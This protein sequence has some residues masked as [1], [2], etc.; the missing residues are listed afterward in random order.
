MK[1]I[2]FVYLLTLSLFGLFSSNAISSTSPPPAISDL[3]SESVSYRGNLPTNGDFIVL[4]L[5]L[6]PA[7]ETYS[8]SVSY[9][10]HSRNPPDEHYEGEWSILR[11]TP[12]NPSAIVYKLTSYPERE[13][14]FFL[15]LNRRQLELLDPDRERFENQEKLRLTRSLLQIVGGV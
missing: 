9:V 14:H 2:F 13:E 3:E 4:S 7:T 5:N 1:I 12:F 15:R 8:L 10:N 11:G 6:Y